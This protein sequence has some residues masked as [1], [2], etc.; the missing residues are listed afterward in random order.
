M[1]PHATELFFITSVP[2]NKMQLFSYIVIRLTYTQGLILELS[3]SFPIEFKLSK[4]ELTKF[5]DAK[6]SVLFSL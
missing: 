2:A 6:D 3:R 5:T 4:A 1:D